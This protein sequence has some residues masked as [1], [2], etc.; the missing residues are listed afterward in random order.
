M[1]RF[2]CF[3]FSRSSIVRSRCVCSKTLICLS[4]HLSSLLSRSI[5]YSSL[6]KFCFLSI[7]LVS[8][9]ELPILMKLYIMLIKSPPFYFGSS[10]SMKTGIILSLTRCN[11]IWNC[12]INFAPAKALSFSMSI[13]WLSK[14]VIYTRLKAYFIVFKS[15]NDCQPQA[16]FG[17]KSDVYIILEA[18]KRYIYFL[19]LI[20]FHLCANSS[21]FM[22]KPLIYC[23]SKWTSFF[24]FDI[25]RI[26]EM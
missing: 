8:A 7:L 3:T 11:K 10:S 19:V 15:K 5:N 16:S 9:L 17:S 20:K 18:F 4:K 12:Y 24:C 1:L 22:S 2:Y 6:T 25:Y 23:S 14:E 21:R 26:F 13:S